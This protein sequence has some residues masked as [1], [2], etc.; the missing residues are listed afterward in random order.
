M[1]FSF[2]GGLGMFLYGMQIMAGGLENL[3]GNRIKTMISSI[4]TNHYKGIAVGA[5]VTALIQSSSATSIMVVGMVNAGIMNL[6]QAAGVIMGANI[7]TTITAWLI[8]LS[9]WTVCFRPEIIAPLIVGL[10]SFFLLFAKSD[11]K[12]VIAEI[13]VGFGILFIGLNFMSDAMEPVQHISIF[14]STFKLLGTYPL[15]GILAGA[16]VTALIQSSSASVGILQT[17]AINGF[18]GWNTAIFITLGQNI[19]TCV[20]A[21]LSSI[22]TD[23][24]AKQAAVFH[25][26]FNLLGAIIIGPVFILIFTLNPDFAHS[27][28]NSIQISIFHTVFNIVNTLILLPFISQLVD[29]TKFFVKERKIV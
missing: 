5:I 14:Y 10:G 2:L 6:T 1:T 28:I 9:E 18:V 20:T 16:I 29:I 13:S 27:R 22:N 25:L 12:K 11:R 21:L 3:S 24:T 17:M 26:L 4:T 8:S 23:R 15:L 7:G 19:G